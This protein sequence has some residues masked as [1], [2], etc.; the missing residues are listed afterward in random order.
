MADPNATFADRLRRELGYSVSLSL[1]WPLWDFGALPAR[2]R[3]AELR[4]ESARSSVIFQRQEAGRQLAQATATLR[5]LWEQIRILSGASPAARDSYLEAESRYRGGVATSL[6][7]LDAY[8]ASVD[9]AVRLSEALSRYR[10]AQSLA[11]RWNQP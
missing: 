7:V 8:A 1:S 3:Q 10:I 11:M 6:E 2:I 5:N 4:L 9:A